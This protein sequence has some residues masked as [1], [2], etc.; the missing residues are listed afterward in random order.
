MEWTSESLALHIVRQEIV[1]VL[2]PSLRRGPR[3]IPAVIALCTRQHRV[4]PLAA[5]CWALIK[6]MAKHWE[7]AEPLVTSF[8]NNRALPCIG[9]AA[10]IARFFRLLGLGIQGGYAVLPTSE[11]VQLKKPQADQRSLARWGHSWRNMFRSAEL[12]QRAKHRREYEGIMEFPVDWEN[13]LAWHRQL[14]GSFSRIGLEAIFAGAMLTPWRKAS[15]ITENRD[16]TCSKCGD[17]R[18]DDFHRLWECTSWQETRAAIPA[19]LRA[20][21]IPYT[22][23]CC[24]ITIGT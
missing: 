7:K 6:I 20:S 21:N 19:H 11:R 17:P 8:A 16:T 14:K 23:F 4:D 5:P 18:D 9:P 10:H 22:K 3:C 12:Q 13:S 2:K 15:K 1:R 24:I